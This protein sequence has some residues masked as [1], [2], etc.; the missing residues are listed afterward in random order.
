MS[1]LDKI[2][3]DKKYKPPEQV[4]HRA[5]NTQRFLFFVSVECKSQSETISM[6]TIQ[7]LALHA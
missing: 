1:F 7:K 2:E 3:N 4:E 6:V 5:L